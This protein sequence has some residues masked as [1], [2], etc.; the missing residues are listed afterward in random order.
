MS[1]LLY[2]AL[3]NK[4]EVAQPAAGAPAGGAANAPTS[5]LLDLIAAIVPAEALAAH[6]AV[7]TWVSETSDS[8]LGPSVTHITHQTEA[9]WAW[10]GL[11]VLSALFYVVPHAFKKGWDAWDVGRA[12]LPA[13]AFAV[14]TMLQPGSLFD[15]ISHWNGRTQAIVAIA[16]AGAVLLASKITA[17]EAEAKVAPSKQRNGRRLLPV[18]ANP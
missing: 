16:L 6:A 9:K 4:R 7:L 17:D 3:T 15:A 18:P 14:W 2:E 1:T 5:K 11:V 8:A 12:L 13:A 10:W